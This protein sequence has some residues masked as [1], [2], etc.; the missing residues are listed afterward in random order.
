MSKTQYILLA[1]LLIIVAVYGIFLYV[2]NKS[3][4]N[5]LSPQIGKNEEQTEPETTKTE[6]VIEKEGINTLE[7]DPILPTPP[8]E[9]ATE[10]ERQIFSQAVLKI[11]E[12]G[13]LFT[14]GENCSF[15]PKALRVNEGTTVTI[16]NADSLS[17]RIY[18]FQ[19]LSVLAGEKKT[20]TAKFPPGKGIYA[21]AC[22]DQT[23]VAYLLVE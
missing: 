19:E 3:G 22:D 9:K 15:S 5:S 20:F 11:A 16:K 23:T 14:V 4:F 8:S 7:T 10:K 1:V 18:L 12:N 2:P 17:H 13:T 21:I 6:K